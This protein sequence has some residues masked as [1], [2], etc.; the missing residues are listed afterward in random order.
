[1]RQLGFKYGCYSR[2]FPQRGQNFASS[3]RT[4]PHFGHILVMGLPSGV[5][6][7]LSLTMRYRISPNMLRKKTIIAHRTPLMPRDSASLY[8]QKRIRIPTKNQ[9][10]GII[11]SSG[12]NHSCA[13]WMIG[14]IILSHLF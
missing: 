3:V 9:S 6:G 7:L 5:P 2:G 8:T 1:M 11:I 4:C 10:S 14:D 13:C 12:R